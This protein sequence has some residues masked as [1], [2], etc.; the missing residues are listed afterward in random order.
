MSELLEQINTYQIPPDATPE[1]ISRYIEFHKRV[2]E[3]KVFFRGYV[4]PDIQTRARIYRAI[5]ILNNLYPEV[6]FINLN[7]NY[8]LVLLHRSEFGIDLN[9]EYDHLISQVNRSYLLKD[10]DNL[11]HD[12]FRWYRRLLNCFIRD[13]L[14]EI[15]LTIIMNIEINRYFLF[16][17]SQG[18]LDQ[19]NIETM[20]SEY[21]S[22][23][24][25]Y[26]IH[27][28]PNQLVS[29]CQVFPWE[30]RI[31]WSV[32]NDQILLTVRAK[33]KDDFH[34]RVDRINTGSTLIQ[35]S[36]PETL[37]DLRS[38][39]GLLK[40]LQA[41]QVTV[42]G[43]TVVIPLIGTNFVYLDQSVVDINLENQD[44]EGVEI[45][46]QDQIS[47]MD[48]YAQSGLIQ[49]PSGNWFSFLAIYQDKRVDP[50]NRIE[51][52]A[53][54]NTEIDQTFHDIST[55]IGKHWLI[56]FPPDRIDPELIR[57]V[58]DSLVKFYLK[59]TD[60]LIW[61]W[62][63]PDLSHTIY[64]PIVESAINVL[65]SKWTDKSIFTSRFPQGLN[66]DPLLIFVPKALEIFEHSNSH[67]WSD[68]LESQALRIQKETSDLLSI[69]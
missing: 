51:F 54:L 47:E 60:R 42:R 14:P 27:V 37:Q 38:G 48:S 41:P 58:N 7:T 25:H 43:P 68:D 18:D 69:C 10:C 67:S 61:I 35:H 19:G 11:T 52:S 49:G 24:V 1:H 44:I 26:T 46:S 32:L 15:D 23:G 36:L 50:T 9:Q 66:W 13:Q 57:V 59:V 63:I 31:G 3:G 17:S 28:Q 8:G 21:R 2:S 45:Y 62:E 53:S 5:H 33:S 56:G 22:G 55:G 6:K 4:K 34:Q 16:L 65:M 40:A 29:T 30:Y 20:W 64:E 12:D 39:W